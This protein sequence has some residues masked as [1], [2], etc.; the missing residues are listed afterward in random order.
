MTL[1]DDKYAPVTAQIGFL[2]VPLAQASKAFTVWRA[3]IHGTARVTPLPGGLVENVLH[4][5]PLTAAVRPRELLIATGNPEWTAVLDCGIRGHD[6]IPPV[7]Y[8]SRALK[9][10]GL[11]VYSVPFTGP[12]SRSPC[13]GIQFSMFGPLRTHFLN[14][15]RTISLVQDRSLLRLDATGTGQFVEETAASSAAS[16]PPRVTDRFTLQ[17]FARY[18]AVLGL[19]PFEEDFYPGPSVLIASPQPV[20]AARALPLAQTPKWLHVHPG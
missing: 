17:M 11:A 5:E 13:G 3:E 4:L 8:L 1:L 18:C 16:S 15:V 12:D 14:Y 7:G 20:P 6:Q 9:C 2:R 10:Q 19:R